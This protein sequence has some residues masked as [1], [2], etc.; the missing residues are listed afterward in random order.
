MLIFSLSQD[1]QLA[2]ILL[3]SQKKYL[4]WAFL[5]TVLAAIMELLPFL[6]LYKIFSVIINYHS[7][8]ANDLIKLA[9]IMAGVILLRYI[10]YSFAYYLSHKAAYSILADLRIK[11]VNKLAYAPLPW[12]CQYSSGKLRQ[13]IVQDVDR[14]EAFVAHHTVEGL[15]AIICPLISCIFLFYFDWRMGLATVIIAPIALLSSFWVTHNMD[16]D[17]DTYMNSVAELDSTTIEYVRN[18]TVM[19]VFNLDVKHFEQMQTRLVNYYQIIQ[20][21][22]HKVIGSWS[23]FASL[24]SANVL[25]ILPVGIILFVYGDIKLATI[26]LAIMLGAGILRPLMKVNQLSSELTEVLAGLRRLIPILALN[27]NSKTSVLMLNTPITLE[28]VRVSFSYQQKPVVSDINILLSPATVTVLVGR[29]GSGKSTIAQLMAGLLIPS[30]GEVRI[31]GV[32]LQQLSDQQKAELIG[33]V[34]QEPFLFQGTI[35]D[36]LCF[37]DKTLTEQQIKIAVEVAQANN[38]IDSLPA[39][40]QT[41]VNEQGLKLS[42]GER[43]RLAIARALLMN[44]NILILDEV[45]AF[46]DNITQKKFYQALRTH[47]TQKTILIIAHNSYGAEYADQ[48]MVMDSGQIQA[49]GNHQYLLDHNFIYRD[50]WQK[51]QSLIDWCIVNKECDV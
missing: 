18:I 47:Y 32:S 38:I 10:C 34:T 37:A 45:T 39:G 28:L 21:I 12:L 2:F 3:R 41:L 6:I 4:F 26:A 43:Q 48:I 29:S 1:K 35:L 7:L 51:Q 9:L 24:L 22:T 25:F 50:M 49:I 14:V 19:K 44:T 46:A 5:L 30:Q 27:S 17:Y 36:N 31:S 13:I 42:G 40:Y 15:A 23:L 33:L 16:K 8:S 11:L 20:V